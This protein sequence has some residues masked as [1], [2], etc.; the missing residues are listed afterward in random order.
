MEDNSNQ[1]EGTTGEEGSTDVQ[2][3]PMQNLKAEYNRK[4]ENMQANMQATIAEQNRQLQAILDGLVQSKQQQAPSAPAKSLK[5]LMYDDPEAFAE[6]IAQRADRVADEKI[7]RTVQ[8]NQATQNVVFEMQNKFPEF[9]QSGSEAAKMAL[10]KAQ[11]VPQ[12]LRGTPEGIR[13]A[14]QEA[15]LELGLVPASKRRSSNNDDFSVSGQSSRGGNRS[16][17]G[18]KDIPEDTMT[19]ARLL[20]PSIE[21]DPKRMEQLKKSVNR[22]NFNRYE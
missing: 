4:L 3:D 9:A 6:H 12:H 20:D 2:P 18:K 1:P 11:A 8:A 10:E 15:A 16:S 7:N 17:S 19:W 14:M 22:K 21:G 5:D 13:L